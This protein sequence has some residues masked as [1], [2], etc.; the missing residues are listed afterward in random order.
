MLLVL[1][2]T[3]R[4]FLTISLSDALL[5]VEAE[6]SIKAIN[7]DL[8]DLCFVSVSPVFDLYGLHFASVSSVSDMCDLFLICVTC[9]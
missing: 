3:S 6:Y 7:S 2:V 8:Y 4:R 5:D 9:F 1:L